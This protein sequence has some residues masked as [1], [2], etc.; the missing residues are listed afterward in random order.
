[1]EAGATNA[2]VPVIVMC[3]GESLDARAVDRDDHEKVAPKARTCAW[4]R[5]GRVL[6]PNRVTTPDCADK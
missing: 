6:I 3:S 2:T 4:C 1:M 5:F